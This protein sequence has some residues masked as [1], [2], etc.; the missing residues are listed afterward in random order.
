MSIN[1]G[2]FVTRDQQVLELSP[3][4]LVH[5]GIGR[6]F[7]P[8]FDD[9][10]EKRRCD[11]LSTTA[12]ICLERSADNAIVFIKNHRPAM[13]RIPLVISRTKPVQRFAFLPSP[14]S[15]SG[16]VSLMIDRRTGFDFIMFDV[17]H[18]PEQLGS[19]PAHAQ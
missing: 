5:R 14:D 16:L 15:P 10:S 19:G 9:H 13:Q 8:A 6:A 17:W 3:Q 4:G 1:A 18:L 7:N 12:D 2:T 11:H